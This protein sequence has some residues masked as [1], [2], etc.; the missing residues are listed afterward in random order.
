MKLKSQIAVVL[1][2]SASI[3]NGCSSGGHNKV[4][5]KR[6]L[7][8]SQIDMIFIDIRPLETVN[9]ALEGLGYDGNELAQS[10][11][12]ANMNAA[13]QAGYNAQTGL[14]GALIGGMIV[15]EAQ[16]NSQINEKNSRVQGFLNDLKTQNWKS[17][18]RNAYTE[19][20]KILIFSDDPIQPYIHNKLF[21]RPLLQVSADYQSL[22]M[23]VEAEIV[24]PKGKSEYRNYF[25]LQSEALLD[26]NESLMQL[27]FKDRQWFEEK[28]QQMLE[29]L[30]ELIKNELS[31]KDEQ[32]KQSA[33]IRFVNDSGEYYERGYLLG[34]KEGY[35]TFRTLRG[36]IKH[37][38]CDKLL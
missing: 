18:W 35:V 11:H 33:P 15:K 3:L 32:V 8:Y 10:M 1:M 4:I 38:P 9:V 6:N 34:F 16:I 13:M 17:H 12:Q 30:P 20:A 26:E 5:T 23:I 14:A 31:A 24:N 37:Y 27:S 29:P 22:H 36:E 19:P 28:L 21:I 2:L 25:Y 7:N